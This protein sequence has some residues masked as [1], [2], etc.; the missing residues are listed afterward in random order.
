MGRKESLIKTQFIY[1]FY[2][3]LKSSMCGHSASTSFIF[4]LSLHFTG[5]WQSWPLKG[6]STL[7][8]V[9]HRGLPGRGYTGNIASHKLPS[10]GFAEPQLN[11]AQNIYRGFCLPGKDK[12]SSILLA[13]ITLERIVTLPPSL[14][15]P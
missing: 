14:P 10:Q 12:G 9:V 8:R 11:I 3:I 13:V 5:E 6:Y 2:F 7:L 1:L 4:F 15:A